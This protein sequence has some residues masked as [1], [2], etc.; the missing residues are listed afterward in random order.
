[1]VAPISVCMI[2]RNEHYHLEHCLKSIRPHVEHL[3]VVDTG[4]IDD[5]VSIAQ[6]YADLVEVF[7]GC[8]DSEG[9]MLRFDVARNRSFSHSK[10]PWTM[11]I[12]GDDEVVGAEN[13]EELCKEYDR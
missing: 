1:M 12:D 6:K 2:V 4:S 13:L 9:R 7:T 3:V 5:S 11:W 8:N 10:L